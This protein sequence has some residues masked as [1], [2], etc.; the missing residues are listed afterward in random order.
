M[1]NWNLN[2]I[3][4]HNYS[5]LSFLT[6][7]NLVYNF[8]IICLSEAYLNSETPPH[9]TQLELSSYNLLLSDYLSVR[10]RSQF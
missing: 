6:D 10:D 8:E 1:D 5:K 7:Y 4:A 9:D 2:S 3:V